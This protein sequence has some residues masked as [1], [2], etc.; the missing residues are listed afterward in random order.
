MSDGLE[1]GP[2]EQYVTHGWTWDQRMQMDAIALDLAGATWEDVEFAD[3]ML[4]ASG[5]VRNPWGYFA[6]VVR[7]RIAMRVLIRRE[8][9]TVGLK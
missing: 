7:E 2:C 3:G 4:V 6:V 9:T 8:M 1:P 5:S